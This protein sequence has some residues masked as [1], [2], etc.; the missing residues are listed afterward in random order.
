MI[1]DTSRNYIS[2]ESIKRSLDSMAANKLNSFHWHIT[3]S[4]SFPLY[5][6]TLPNMAYYGAYSPRQV[7]YP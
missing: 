4:H 6:E 3:D 7:Y 2:V 1:L 5:L